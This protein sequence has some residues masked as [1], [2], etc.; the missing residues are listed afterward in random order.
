MYHSHHNA[1]DQVGRGLLGGVRGGAEEAGPPTTS[2]TASTS[3]SRNDTLGGFT[4]NGHGFP[5]TVPVLAAQG[6]TVRVRFMNEGTMMHPWHIHGYRMKVVARDGYPLE[7]AAFDCDT[8]GVNPGERY[9][10]NIT[11]DRLG[12]LG[13]PLPHP[14]P[15]RGRRTACSA[16]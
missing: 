1:T 15:R 11:A 16:W 3:G 5:A 2:S 12:H 6:E 14:P 10:V 8:L 9:D 7:G 4:I 13:V